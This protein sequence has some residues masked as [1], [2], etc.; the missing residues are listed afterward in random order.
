MT[1][2]SALPP[3]VMAALAKG[4]KIEAIKLLRKSSKLGLAE[5]KGVIDAFLQSQ[6]VAP[7]DRPHTFSP[8]SDTQRQ[9]DEKREYD[10]PPNAPHIAPLAP[11]PGNLAPGEVAYSNSS[12]W[13]VLLLVGVLVAYYLFSR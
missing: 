6:G 5:T 11:R 3:D 10:T 8:P 4:R 13:I 9:P 12:F 1:K 2:P 7:A